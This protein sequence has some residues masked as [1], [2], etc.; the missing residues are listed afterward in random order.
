MPTYIEGHLYVKA[1]L[2]VKAFQMP[3]YSQ[4][5]FSFSKVNEVFF[6]ILRSL[7]FLVILKRDFHA[8]ATYTQE[9][10]V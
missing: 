3:A 5:S 9:T 4:H 10:P 1:H 2:H 8:D 7:F 6:G